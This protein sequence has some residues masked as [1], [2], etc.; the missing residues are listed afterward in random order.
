MLGTLAADTMEVLLGRNVH[1]LADR[2]ELYARELARIKNSIPVRRP[3]V[4]CVLADLSL[5][6]D[7]APY[8]AY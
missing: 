1:Y 4:Y 6:E 2:P 5:I 8:L 7:P 3:N